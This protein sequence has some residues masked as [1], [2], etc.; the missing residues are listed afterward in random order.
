MDK[1]LNEIEI[2]KTAKVFEEMLWQTY[3]PIYDISLSC[4]TCGLPQ[5]IIKKHVHTQEETRKIYTWSG[6]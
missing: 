2:R 4:Q 3:G 6:N 1:R 5:G